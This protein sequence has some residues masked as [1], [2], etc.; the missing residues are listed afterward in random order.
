MFRNS[1]QRGMAR[2]FGAVFFR[3]LD[4]FPV[5]P[6]FVHVFDFGFAENVRMAADQFINEMPRDLFKIKRAALVRQLA[7]ENYLQ[8]QIAQFLG[9]LNV[10]ARLDGVNQFINFLNRVAAQRQVRL[11]AVPRTA[12]GRTQPR[13][14]FEQIVYRRLFFHL[15]NIE[16]STSNIEHPMHLIRAK[17]SMLGVRCWLLD[18]QNHRIT[19]SSRCTSSTRASF[20]ARISSALNLAMPR[21][22]S[23]PSRSQIRT[24]SLA[25]KFPSQRATPGGNK[26]FPDSRKAF[27]APS[28]TASMPFG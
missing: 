21:A 19:K 14:D 13:H 18:V 1:V 11:L 7:V 12:R 5:R 15:E 20:L 24:T 3:L 22:N 16:H 2:V 9:H 28:S 10:V 26:L 23:V 6:D 4:F 27:F 17:N 8:Q 25:I